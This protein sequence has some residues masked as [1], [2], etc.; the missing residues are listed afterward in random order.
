MSWKQCLQC[1]AGTCVYGAENRRGKRSNRGHRFYSAPRPWYKVVTREM[2]M[3]KPESA[4]RA[5]STEKPEICDL[6]IRWENLFE[7]LSDVTWDDGTKRVAGTL[8]LMYED[9]QWKVML[10]DKGLQR[11]AFV[12]G[13]TMEEVL[14]KADLNVRDDTLDW[15]KAKVWK[16]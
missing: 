9:G 10:N 7:F 1:V 6:A 3:K 5:A 4:V 11:V 12:S 16:K 2:S 15:R 13:K 14:D 8:L